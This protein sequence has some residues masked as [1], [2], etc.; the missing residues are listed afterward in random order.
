ML[1][2]NLITEDFGIPADVKVDEETATIELS[3]ITP[4]ERGCS[5]LAG[6]EREISALATDYPKYVRVVVK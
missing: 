2:I 6:L 4:D 3:L 1:A 5:I